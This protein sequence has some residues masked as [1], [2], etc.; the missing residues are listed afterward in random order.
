MS[1]VLSLDS[2]ADR[3]RQPAGGDAAPGHGAE[4]TPGSRPISASPPA[5]CSGPRSSTCCPRRCAWGRR[6]PFAGRPWAS[7][8]SSSWSGSSRSIITSRKSRLRSTSGYG[9][10]RPGSCT[11]DYPRSSVDTP[12]HAPHRASSGNAE[13]AEA[14]SWGTAAFGLAVHSLVGGVALASAIAADFAARRGVGATGWGVFLAT[15]LH[16]PAD[17]LTIVSLMLRSGVPR[18]RAHLVNFGF[19]LM[20]P[21]GVALFALG[22]GQLGPAGG[23]DLDGRRPLVLGG[24]LPLH[25]PERPPAGAAVPLPRPPQ[26]LARAPGRLLP[27]G[28][29]LGHRV[30]LSTGRPSVDKLRRLPTAGVFT[31]L[32]GAHMHV[33]MHWLPAIDECSLADSTVCIAGNIGLSVPPSRGRRATA[34]DRYSEAT[35]GH[36]L[37]RVARWDDHPADRAWGWIWWTR[38]LAGFHAA[39]DGMATPRSTN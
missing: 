10:N 37:R 35:I 28:R 3:R 6:R 22:L 29:N 16:K 33:S 1:Y 8:R 36:D 14:L 32:P 7:F 2:A 24:D 27:D 4:L 20:I 21:T 13:P 38:R 17:A 23:V 9:R 30:L 31:L 12:H 5:A 39:Q 15:V 34:L 11:Q 19:A 18:R 25:R 26:A